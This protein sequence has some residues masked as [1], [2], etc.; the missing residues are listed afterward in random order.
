MTAR[1]I[2]FSGIAYLAALGLGAFVVF[3][4]VRAAP[5][6]AAAV[7]RAVSDA[8]QAVNPV[9]PENVFNQAA[10]SVTA[11]L[12]GDP[13]MTPGL[14]LETKIRQLTGNTGEANGARVLD[15]FTALDQE[16]ADMGA[17]MKFLQRRPDL[18]MT[19]AD[20]ED[21]DIGAAMS[22]MSGAA[23]INYS[24]LSRGVFRR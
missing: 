6:S 17:A 15:A 22:A 5:E 24:H 18:L 23:F 8:V 13:G 20:Q 14:W 12:T 21:A 3:R 7:G 9:N 4:V 2:D 16:D 11:T 19:A 10:N 1:G